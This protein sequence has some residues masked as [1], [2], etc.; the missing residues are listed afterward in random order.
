ME[1]KQ[2]KRRNLLKNPS[3][4]SC[5]KIKSVIIHEFIFYIFHPY[6]IYFKIFDQSFIFRKEHFSN[7]RKGQ[8]Q[9]VIQTSS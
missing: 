1:R 9:G 2:K 7:F 4:F 5:P 3:R 6:I 8:L